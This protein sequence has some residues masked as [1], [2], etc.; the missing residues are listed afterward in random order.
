MAS[1]IPGYEYDIFISYRQKDN[2]YDGWVTE[3]VDNLKKELEATF[4][5]EI[6]VYF[7]INPHDGL[8]ETHDVDASL[9]E[10]L[11]CLVFIPIISRTYCDPKSFAWEHEFKAFIEQA[12]HDQFG[13]KAKLLNGNIASRVLPVRIH[14]LGKD[15]IIFFESVLRG[16]FRSVDFIYKSAGVN[17]PLRANEDHPHDN[18]NK[19]YYRDQINKVANAIEEIISSL[20]RVQFTSPEEKNLID[21]SIVQDSIDLFTNDNSFPNRNIQIKLYP[22]EQ[23]QNQKT[24]RVQ[25]TL[26]H[27][28]KYFYKYIFSFLLIV[29]IILIFLNRQDQI[30]IF[31]AGKA[32][33]ELAK[34]HVRNAVTYIDQKEYG[35]AKAEL[36]NALSVDPKYSY[37]WSTLAALSVKQGNL[38][39]ALTETIKA[40]KYDP[41]NSQAAYNMGFAFHDKKDYHQA[42]EWYRKAITIDST[43]KKDSVLVPAISAL[44]NLYNEI[45]QTADAVLILSQAEDNYKESKYIYLIYRNLGNSYFLM[46]QNEEAIK[47]LELSQ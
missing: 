8:L 10:K 15:D 12:S 35:A 7:D 16:G 41:S 38:N 23:E 13:L 39:N 33:R 24:E 14:D 46:G 17:R 47:Y 2:K 36:D 44:G 43:F 6:T 25:K 37:A 1:L 21:E 28:L 45:N 4:K 42:I 19:I 34:S 32:K 11:K 22:Q 40:V 5:E 3:F 27:W 31:G 20:K 9:K 30:R 29:S 26:K 18:Y